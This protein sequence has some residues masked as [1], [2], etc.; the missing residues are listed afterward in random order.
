MGELVDHYGTST[1]RTT[2]ATMMKLCLATAALIV[3]A[4]ALTPSVKL[5]DGSMMP[6]IAAG[7]WQYKHDQVQQ[8]ISA[9]LTVGYRHIDTAHDYC[10]NGSTGDCTAVGKSVQ[11]GVGAAV[12]SS[13]LARDQI[14]LTTKV[15]GCGKQGIG[16]DTCAED[17]V[18]AAKDNL[19]Q[20]GMSYTDLLLVHF[21]PSGG[22]GPQNCVAMRKQWQ[23]LTDEVLLKNLT[24]TLGVSNFC[25]SCLKCLAEAGSDVVTPAVNQVEFHIGMGAD[26]EG[27]MSYSAGKGIIVEAYSPLGTNTTELING[28]LTTMIGAAHNKSSPEVALNWILQHIPA[29]TTKSA[30]PA[31]L[32]EDLAVLDWKLTETDMQTLDAATKPSG[33]PSFMCSN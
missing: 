16:F 9:A 31:H 4:N 14:Y 23:A 5:N 8:A 1:L 18:A 17:S 11:Q 10:D 2:T 6:R 26:P 28:H 22:C 32:A 19:M 27:L 13:A 7:T 24:R 33:T 21:P 30:N 20:L 29:V 25:V 15:P 12:S 3:V